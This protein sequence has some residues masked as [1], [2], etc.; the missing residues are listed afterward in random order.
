[1]F[2]T[3]RKLHLIIVMC[4]ASLRTK[5]LEQRRK[6]I[7]CFSCISE[8]IE[9]QLIQQP[10]PIQ[11]ENNLDGDG[12]LCERRKKSNFV[13]NDLIDQLNAFHLQLLSFDT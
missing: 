9:N 1:M 2:G 12:A 11:T 6:E 5:S 10:T 7:S 3:S 13:E 8:G 4:G